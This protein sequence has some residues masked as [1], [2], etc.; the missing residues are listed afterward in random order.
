MTLYFPVWSTI[1]TR[2]DACLVLYTEIGDFKV[3]EEF[4][5]PGFGVFIV[6]PGIT[7]NNNNNNNKVGQWMCAF[8]REG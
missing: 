7:C 5:L 1:H 6:P 2:E 8:P 3:G 4:P